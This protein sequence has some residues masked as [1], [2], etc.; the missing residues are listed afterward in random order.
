MPIR[1]MEYGSLPIVSKD[2]TY[3]KDTVIDTVEMDN[4]DGY[5][6][7]STVTGRLVAVKVYS[8]AFMRHSIGLEI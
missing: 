1:T 2:Y 8:G 7:R 4:G 6:I 3:L 5:D